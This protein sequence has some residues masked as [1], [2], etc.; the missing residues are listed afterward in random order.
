MDEKT[1]YRNLLELCAVPS[2]SE[3]SGEKE[4]PEKLD[5]MLKRIRYF[6]ENPE[7]VRVLPVPG[8]PCGRSY[9]CALMEGGRKSGKTVLLLSHFDVVGTEDFGIAKEL[10]FD[11]EAYTAYLRRHTELELPE[12]ARRDLAAGDWLFGRGTMDMK[13]GIAAN[14]AVLE[15]AGAVLPELEGNLLFLSVPDEEA[16]SAG[17]RAAAEFLQ[18]L[19]REKQLEYACCFVSEPHFPKFPG[20]GG[21]YIYTGTVGKLLP[22]F[23]CFGV[24]TH[25][26]EPF[27]GLNPNLLT[28]K[29]TEALDC[30]PVY[31]DSAKGTVSP[32]PVCLKQSDVKSEYSV[33]TPEMAYV[34]FNYMTLHKTPQEV[35]GEM[36]RAAE[37]AFSDAFAVMRSRAESH[38]RLTGGRCCA[39]VQEGKVLSWH[40]LY[41]WCEKI[42]GAAFTE[43]MENLLNGAKGTETPDL[44][45]LSVEMVREARKFCPYA[46]PMI[47]VLFAPPYYPHAAAQEN[48]PALPLCRSV[49]KIARERYGET[50]CHEP[51]FPGLSDMSYLGLSGDVRPA[52]LAQ[53]F[54][55]WGSR[56]RIPLKAMAALNI[57]FLCFGPEGKDAHKRTERLHLPYAMHTAAPLLWDAVRLALGSE[58]SGS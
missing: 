13:F 28:A 14:L 40:A 9:V 3:S 30:S 20:D 58:K 57:P 47:V 18:A 41:E 12:D 26:G 16:N 38:A 11:P 7:Q 15:E 44:R 22:V 43:H 48:S 29:L 36:L 50:L 42:H 56:Y 19:R 5:G 33:Q 24:T 37:T 55:V 8:D 31:A 49:Q 51:F 35:M 2:V 6:A 39:A 34:Y 17:M 27:S 4:M 52:E 45:L 1:L 23:C 10:A 32:P 53:D 46:G 21:K 25:A 54:P